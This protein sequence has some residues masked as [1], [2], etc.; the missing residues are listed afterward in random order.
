MQNIIVPCLCVDT[1]TL[2]I[3]F[4]LAK[5]IFPNSVSHLISSFSSVRPSFSGFLTVNCFR[6]S[7]LL[8]VNT[9]GGLPS[10]CLCV[11]SSPQT[12]LLSPSC[13]SRSNYLLTYFLNPRLFPSVVGLMA[14][15]IF[16]NTDVIMPL[17]QLKSF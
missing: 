7:F 10:H 6:H 11:S 2:Q 5:I 9:F 17:P 1:A 8:P 13:R 12:A 15:L 4:L 14:K 3:F 16:Q